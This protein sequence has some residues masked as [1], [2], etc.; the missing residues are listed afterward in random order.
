M[1][2]MYSH[3][4]A[5]KYFIFLTFYLCKYIIKFGTNTLNI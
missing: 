4:M 2:W 1:L 3:A 5:A